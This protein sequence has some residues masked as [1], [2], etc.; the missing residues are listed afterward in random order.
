MFVQYVIMLDWMG[1]K[2]LSNIKLFLL[3]FVWLTLDEGFRFLY[4]LRHNYIHM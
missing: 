2:F 3:F 4:I 1:T